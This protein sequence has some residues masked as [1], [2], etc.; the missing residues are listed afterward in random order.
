MNAANHPAF[1]FVDGSSVPASNSK[2]M[3]GKLMVLSVAR[4]RFHVAS[5]GAF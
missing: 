4:K 1:L 2:W 5:I 3:N